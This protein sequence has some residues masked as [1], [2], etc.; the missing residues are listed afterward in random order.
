MFIKIGT[1]L[2]NIDRANWIQFKEE[3]KELIVDFGHYAYSVK[4][5]T[6][7]KY[8]KQIEDEIIFLRELE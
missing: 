5:E 8:F 7:A 2:V 6:M 3:E 1:R 4:G